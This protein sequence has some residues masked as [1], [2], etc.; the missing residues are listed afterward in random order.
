MHVKLQLVICHD[1]GHEETVTD[2]ITLNK[3]H[4]RIEH[5]GLSLA[6]SKQLLSSLQRHLLQQQ[7]NTFLNTHATCPDCGT[8]LTLKAHGSRSFRTL[9]G[10]FKFYSPRLEHCD[11]K[12]HNTASFRPLSA[13]LTEPVAPELLYMEA[14]WSSLVS[15][16]LSLD[17]LKDFLPIAL[18]LDVKTVRYDTLKVAK[19]L[20]AELNED[21]TSFIEGEPHDW[22]LLPPPESSF[23]VGIDGGY[24]RNWVD[25]KHK[26]EVI[27]GKSI[28]SFDESEGEDK[29]P[30]LKRFGFVQTLETKSKRRLYEVLHSQ[31]LQMNQ[32]ITFL[33]DGDNT[34]R[35]LQL[36]MSPKATH[37]LDWHHVTMK[38][39]VLSQY[40]KGLVH[41]ETVLGEAICDK[42]DRLKWSLWHGQVDKALGKIDDLE[43]SIESFKE[44]Y[45]RH[46]GLVKAL[47]ELRTY[48]VNNRHVIPNYGERYRNGEPIAT[49]FVES[50]VN[51]VVSKRFC[52][53]QQMQW[54]KEG[55]HLLLQ[56]RVRTLN[57]ELAGIFKRWYSDLDMK[58]EAIPLAA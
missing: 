11:C 54:S 4:Q 57:G 30:S 31:G 6:E 21:Q 41:C 51:E 46:A 40:G 35:Q 26:F 14:K 27:V 22:E 43:S 34:L 12:R 38:L 5:L 18:S 2:V 53:K 20:E 42:I 15:Y 1:D 58:A 47:S 36:E 25:K 55:A 48:I 56:T 44:T 52:K 28:R 16:G 33:S 8:P 3:N 29:T 7:I 37:I 45:A 10:T 32:E 23:T 13:L 17:A 50:T 9:F 39:T 49:G 19:R 24:V